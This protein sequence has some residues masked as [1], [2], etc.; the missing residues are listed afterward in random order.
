MPHCEVI[1]APL[2]SESSHVEPKTF[3]KI[4]KMFIIFH[5]FCLEDLHGFPALSII[6]E[7]KEQ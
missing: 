2:M 1:E 7:S 4:S 6:C 3:W 5:Y